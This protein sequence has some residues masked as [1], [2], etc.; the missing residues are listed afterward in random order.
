MPRQYRVR[1]T[2]NDPESPGSKPANSENDLPAELSQLRIGWARPEKHL[3]SERLSF[4]DEDEAFNDELRNPGR[5]DKSPA[6]IRTPPITSV[7]AATESDLTPTVPAP[8][9]DLT[10]PHIDFADH[11]P[12]AIHTLGSKG[13]G[14]LATRSIAAGKLVLEEEAVVSAIKSRLLSSRCSYCGEE[15]AKL[16]R[17]AACKTMHYY[18]SAADPGDMEFAGQMTAATMKLFGD[19]SKLDAKQCL[20]T[21]FMLNA[22]AFGWI[23]VD[24]VPFGT[25]FLP[26]ISYIN[27]DC[28]PNCA[29]FFIRRRAQ[30]RALRP[31][32]KGEEPD[33]PYTFKIHP[34]SQCQTKW[35][36]V[37]LID[38]NKWGAAIKHLHQDSLD[39]TPGTR[40]FV[41]KA[42]EV[43]QI[44]DSYLHPSHHLA[45]GATRDY[46][47]ACII[48]Q[49]SLG[50]NND[51]GA[52]GGFAF[53][54]A[55][56]SLRLEQALEII[57]PS[58]AIQIASQAFC[59][60]RALIAQSEPPTNSRLDGDQ[61]AHLQR[62]VQRLRNTFG[63][64]SDS[65][66][67]ISEAVAIYLHE[68]HKH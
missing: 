43:Y 49:A 67:E 68:T 40:Q 31:I 61:L 32:A 22:N 30:L 39:P 5:A 35:S 33:N 14:L 3:A 10:I 25:A 9:A 50:D 62:G 45:V 63:A 53:E 56:L 64:A 58:T 57:L 47:M 36:I 29:Y 16:Q 27:H 52:G 54:V 34:C 6:A 11:H 59:T 65:Y 38:V 1:P 15:P 44:M 48:Y 12:V 46:L 60:A 41:E 51:D 66:L 7:V 19:S 18:I 55:K 28:N 37:D 17:C 23:N 21:W 42:R 24:L 4:W 20:T 26:R 8:T 2:Q 13:R